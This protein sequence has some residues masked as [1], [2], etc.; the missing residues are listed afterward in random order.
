L[1]AEFPAVKNPL[2][3]DGGSGI[4]SAQ[5]TSNNPSAEGFIVAMGMKGAA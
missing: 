1:T 5:V 4:I 3:E 2:V